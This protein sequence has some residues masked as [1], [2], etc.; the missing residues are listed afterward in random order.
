LTSR[1]DIAIWPPVNSPV[2]VATWLREMA[3]LTK[4]TAAPP[5]FP[6]DAARG[7]G[8]IVF[9][10]PGFCA[11]DVSTARLREFLTRQGFDPRPWD[12][13][14]NI[15]PTRTA[16]AMFQH[17]LEEVARS[18]GPVALV[19]MSLGGT[20]AREIAKRCPN[21]VKRVITIVSP[22]KLPVATP[23]APLAQFASLLWE[24]D[25]RKTFEHISDPPLVPVTA[26]VSPKDGV[27]DWRACVPESSLNVEIVMIDGA[28][29]TMGSNPQLQRTV[30]A[31]LAA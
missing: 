1:P 26:I 12:C 15:G 23:L 3:A 16:M 6:D 9:V 22:I 28:H 4:V 31:R 19:G 5:A 21:S 29:M 10:L 8:E 30:A 11:P 13:G 2:S 14:P 18:H 17:Q 7:R 20:I 25:A 27:V 24:A